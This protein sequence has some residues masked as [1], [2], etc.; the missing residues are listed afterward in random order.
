MK[1]L[2]AILLIVIFTFSIIGCDKKEELKVDYPNEADFEAA[3]NAGE[4]LIG[5]TVTFTVTDFK[6]DSA[7][8][9]NLFAGEHLNFV[10]SEHPNISVG[11]T[12]TVKVTNVINFLQSWIINY[13]KID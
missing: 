2:I 5:K 13:E 3:L 7:F 4:N 6:P 8:G 11:E 12:V 9:Y 1:K 10:S